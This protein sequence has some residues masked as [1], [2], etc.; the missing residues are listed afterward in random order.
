[1][2]GNMTRIIA[3]IKESWQRELEDEAIRQACIQAGHHWRERELGPVTT[4]KMFLLQIVYGNVA[5]NFVPHLAGK[6]VSGS[7]YCDAR[8]R[9]PL[10]ALEALLTT[11][12][13]RM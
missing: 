11:C 12:T 4:V 7:S 10:A 5:C 3:R 13:Q 1:M 6:S 9:L 2:F 8:S